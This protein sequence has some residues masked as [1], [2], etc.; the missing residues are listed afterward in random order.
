MTKALDLDL[1]KLKACVE[2][3]IEEAVAK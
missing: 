2:Q 3:L 1:K